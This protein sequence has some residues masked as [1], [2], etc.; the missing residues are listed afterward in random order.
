MGRRMGRLLK[1][2]EETSG[3]DR[4]HDD[5]HFGLG[6]LVWDGWAVVQIYHHSFKRH[7]KH[8]PQTSTNPM[9]SL[10]SPSLWTSLDPQRRTPV[11][12]SDGFHR[13]EP[14]ELGIA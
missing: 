10:V 6:P 5:P 14:V 4:D 1:I 9:V 3:G 13:I 7:P 12:T 2:S 8:Q 11:S